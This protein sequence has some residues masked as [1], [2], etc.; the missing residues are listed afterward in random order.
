MNLNTLK[1]LLVLLVVVDHNDFSRSI[2]PGFLHGFSFHVVGFLI[3]PFLK[4]AAI[5]S[6]DY[7][8]YVFRLYFPFLVIA[9]MTALIVFVVTPVTA[10]AQTK[11]WLLALYS[12]NSDVLKQT[13]HMALLWFLPS[14]I[15][16]VSIYTAIQNSSRAGK[17]TA[18]ALLCAAHLFI[19]TLAATGIQRYL[20]LGVLPALYVVPLAYLGVL[21][22]QKFYLPVPPLTAI[23]I[24][25]IIFV[26][27]K[28][29]Q[30]KAGLRT[31]IGFSEVADFSNPIGLLLNDL[32]AIGGVLFLFQ[33]SRIKLGAFVDLCGKYSLQIYLFHAFVA[34]I[35]YKVLLRIGA[36]WPVLILFA[37]S[38][39]IT[40]L[41][42]AWLARLLGEHKLVKRFLF[43]RSPREFL[44][45]SPMPFPQKAMLDV[46]ASQD[47]KTD[48]TQ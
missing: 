22:H 40:V 2:F 39:L 15:A 47:K 30:M 16:L 23:L 33:L 14:F 6:N 8:N 36:E 41:A 20:P 7:L 42:T 9:T 34:L 1:G 19:G 38:L 12:G 13:T 5:W 27:I 24:S 44:G 10:L 11:L 31:E 37:S 45:L 29:T 26:A 18:I 32:E 4:P 28:Y 21:I 17:A 35:V 3:I 25:T 43:P 48:A 46:Q